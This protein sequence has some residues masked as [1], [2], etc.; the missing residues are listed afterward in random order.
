[1][2]W[3]DVTKQII[4]EK[5]IVKVEIKDEEFDIEVF[6]LTGEQYF[7]AFNLLPVGIDMSDQA[8]LEQVRDGKLSEETLMK[9]MNKLK[10]DQ[11]RDMHRDFITHK[12]YVLSLI[13][14]KNF[15]DFNPDLLDNMRLMGIFEEVYITAWD[16]SN[17]PEDLKKNL[18]SQ[19]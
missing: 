18:T 4:G 6:P 9:E 10:A 15:D 16:M 17:P 14:D 13:L 12:Q 1:M 7:K 2:N 8:M 11:Q 19:S 3:N 5:K